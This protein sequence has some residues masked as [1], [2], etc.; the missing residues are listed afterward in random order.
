MAPAGNYQVTTRVVRGANVESAETLLEANIDSVTLGR[1][2]EG[3][4]LNLV[5]GEA[6]PL[7]QVYQ[8]I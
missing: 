8:I 5:G 4:T 1:S 7:S 3:M 2:G 6:L